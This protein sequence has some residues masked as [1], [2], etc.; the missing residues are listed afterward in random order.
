MHALLSE[1]INK[2]TGGHYLLCLLLGLHA[3]IILV[4]LARA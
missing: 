2:S 1:Q 3:I 4:A